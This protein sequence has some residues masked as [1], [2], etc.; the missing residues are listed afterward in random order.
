MIS[1]LYV[2][3]ESALLE[4]TKIYLEAA[5]GY[6]VDTCLSA[7]DALA[8]LSTRSYD[9]VVS[10]YQMPEMDGLAFLIRLREN[11]P[12]LPFILFTGR[13]REEVAIAALNSGADFYLQKGGEPKSQFA[14]LKNKIQQAV[15][16]RRAERA[17]L[18]SEEH[19][20]GI[21]SNAPVGIFHSTPEGTLVD[22]NPV[23]AR[24]F[25]YD[26]PEAMIDTVNHG[27][28]MGAVH[29]TDPADR[30]EIVRRIMETEG[31][32]TST[33]TFRK[34]DGS[35]FIS[36]MSY[37][38]YA[39][40]DREV[41]ELEGFVVD[42]TESRKA[43]ARITAVERRYH[44]IFD[45]AGDA[46]LVLDGDTGT[47]L[48]AN[49]AAIRMFGYSREE[50]STLNHANLFAEPETPG[51]GETCTIQ[52]Q[53]LVYY[54]K[55]DGT[56]FAAEITTSRY[57]QKRRTISI[58]SVRDITERK[59]AEERVIAAQRL[60]AV[61]SQ[62][63][64]TI[65]R[66]RDL[67]TLLS[68][69]CRI[70]VEYGKFRM[71]WVG[72]LD[73]ES[74]MIRPV[75]HAGSEEGYLAE[76]E[77]TASEG[78]AGESPA[79]RAIRTGTY[80]ICNDITTDPRM[81]L[82]RNEALKRGYRSN[83][84]FPIHLHGEVV[85]AITIYAAEPEFFNEEEIK[86]LDEI[87]MDVSFAL[88]MLDEQ[89]RR[90]HAETALAG[91]AERVQ[92]LAGILERASQPF[93]MADPDFRFGIV[94]PAFCELTGYPEEELLHMSLR[95]LTPQKYHDTMEEMFRELQRTG[96]PRRYE[97]E[98]IRKDGSFVPVEVL[99]HRVTDDAGNLRYV[100]AFA[101][102]IT[103]RRRA[104]EALRAERDQAQRYLDV[105]GVML[106][107]MDRETRVTLI[108]RKGS[109]ILGYP[110][111]EILGREWAESFVPEESREKVQGIIR[112]MLN[113]EVDPFEYNENLLLTKSGEQRLVAFH[114]TLLTAPSGEILGLL[115]SG[116]DIT[117]QRQVEDALRESEERFRNLIQNSSDMIR[118][119]DRDTRILY[120][121]PSTLRIVGYD[122][123]DVIG[124]V[125]L[126][127]V[128]PDDQELVKG[129][130][131]KVIDRTNRGIATEYR[132]RHAD[133]HYVDVESVSLNLLDVPAI[134]GL[135][136]TT[137]PITERR[138]AEQALKESEA[139]YRSIFD[140]SA[141][142]IL[143]VNGR[144]LDCNPEAERMFGYTRNELLDLPPESL[145]P[146]VQPDGRDSRDVFS[147]FMHAA[148]EGV[149]QFFAWVNKKKD[150]SP[151]E[152]EV[153]VRAAGS[154]GESR[155]IILIHD[156]T[157]LNQATSQTRRLA[158]F[159][160]RNPEPVIECT[161]AKEITYVNPATSVVL[162]RCGLPENPAAFLPE[163]MDQIISALTGTG[164]GAISR[165]V[166]VGTGVFR[167]TIVAAPDDPVLRI[168]A[169]DITEQ[170]HAIRALEEVIRK[171]NLLS[172]IT[173]HDIKNRLTGVFGYLELTRGMI[174]DPAT[175]NY[176]KQVEKSADLI[177]QQIEFTKEY[178]NLGVKQPGWQNVSS[179]IE[180][181][182]RDLA[183]ENVE[184]VNEAGRLFV[185]ADAMLQ[186][187]IYN[188]MENSLQHGGHVSR[189]RFSIRKS[190][191]HCILSCEDDGEGIPESEK[192][193][194]FNRT[195][196][197]RAG[198]GLF[199]SREILIITGITIAEN[200]E[201]GKG[202]RFELTIPR[203]KYRLEPPA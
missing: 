118:I 56:V 120:S 131:G 160:L 203:G 93:A 142:A 162:E 5:G 39:R 195:A 172:S 54:R 181:G 17:L 165:D 182:T 37:R 28:G 59:K 151:L 199:L 180:T 87:A 53:P 158:A 84:S 147:G 130:I 94:N 143:L 119:L 63:N 27:A 75:A 57:P 99:I 164:A 144:I 4:V 127:F 89:A 110:E 169:H 202:A 186:R 95:D 192:E 47:I 201:P 102:D 133:G 116:Q 31:W 23:F 141:D 9:I 92:F 107:V 135:V 66:V 155:L 19:F 197:V 111:E 79:G 49:P 153:S 52:F 145:S 152:T 12:T 112:Q 174:Q 69:V 191:D 51:S 114:N 126:D 73:H 35:T 24:M 45:A 105:A 26:S 29:Y 104:E 48:D 128:H 190:P 121:S 194:I 117:H 146:P 136:T 159:P 21:F 140:A 34:R 122:P 200:G 154:A 50:F 166:L 108:N 129:A 103:G 43:E 68:D 80:D 41:R 106:A 2:D 198:I 188:L 179:L 20:R 157:G 100:Y 60:Y 90:T 71:V 96:I 168:Y 6:A 187:V 22:V 193:T 42:I 58:V 36:L 74:H 18:E 183:S 65:V 70:A 196:K 61:L 132:I 113:G 7:Q 171:L 173:R 3:D 161:A 40:P 83:A 25:G 14:E 98:Y 78:V 167:V 16:R 86:L 177:R 30:N 185:Y 85:G 138:K 189:I 88:D 44:N 8:R 13:G 139:R 163:D 124:K 134:R 32:S 62:I 125:P 170:A 11:Y 97:K 184:V 150:G 82:W 115:F 178:E 101:T 64:Q 148:R 38:S 77:I 46:M 67:E 55:K 1:I 156:V 72:L 175:L 109:E 137:R 10:D 15:M 81:D 149:P 91:S 123:A 76:V 33:I 176:L